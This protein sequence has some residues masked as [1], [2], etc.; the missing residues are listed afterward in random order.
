MTSKEYMQC[1]TSV[2][3]QWLAELGPMFYSV[4]DSNKT[5]SERRLAAIEHM[6]Q[7]E[8]EMKEA[9]EQIRL[10]KEEQDR[11][12]IGSKR[13]MIVTPGRW[14]PGKREPGTPATPKRGKFGL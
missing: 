5:R 2:D 4:K 3:G 12:V 1:V 14:D 10:R 11:A 13:S 8:E 7:M 9:Q 6:T